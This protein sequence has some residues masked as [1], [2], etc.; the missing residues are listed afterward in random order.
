MSFLCHSCSGRVLAA[1]V[2]LSAAAC[3][4]VPASAGGG[5]AEGIQAD[6]E[7]DLQAIR[8]EIDALRAARNRDDGWLDAAR[9]AEIR[10]VVGDVL[11]DAD[12]RT[13]FAD[14]P[15]IAGW[16]DGFRIAS[17]D[18]DFLLRISGE[19]QVRYVMNHRR[20][21]RPVPEGPP[22]VAARNP[23][24]TVRGLENRRTRIR[25]S[26]HVGDPR[27]EYTAQIGF[28]VAGGSGFLEL[29]F[30]RFLLGE[31]WNL[32]VGQFRPRF[33]REF[34]VPAPDQ[35]AVE[36][37]VPAIYFDPGFVQGAQVQWQSDEWRVTGWFGDGLGVP[38]LQNSPWNRTPTQWSTFGRLEW[39]PEGVWSQFNDFSSPPG[40]DPGLMIGADVAGQRLNGR[41]PALDGVSQVTASADVSVELGGTSAMATVIWQQSEGGEQPSARPWGVVAQVG[42]FVAEDV[43]LFARYACLQTDSPSLPDPDRGRWNGLTVGGSW[44]AASRFKVTADWGINA[45]SL[46]DT[47][48]TVNGAGLRVD[49]A[50]RTGQWLLRVQLSLVY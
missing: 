42:R 38:G 9:A 46:S 31:G 12:A 7:A 1:V 41:I 50:G 32:Q 17:A 49:E 22:A 27:I 39:K 28:R 19:M 48:F 11:A 10:V 37:S 21:D 29:G 47:D 30:L 45:A 5:E 34:T 23:P 15:F 20:G 36:R 3:P 8:A 35:L 24:G 43:E 13:S 14:A 40:T 2:A 44:Y 25:F 16:N 6:L 26:G 18:G 4:P 33:L